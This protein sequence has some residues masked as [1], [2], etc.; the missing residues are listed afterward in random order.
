[1]IA[2]VHLAD[3]GFAAAV[4]LRRPRADGLIN[5]DVAL[6]LPLSSSPVRV[7]GGRAGLIA[8]WESEDALDRFLGSHPLAAKFAGGWHARLEPLRRWGSW[9]GLPKTVPMDR[10][11]DYD[12]PAV[13]LTLGRLR[14]S[15]TIRFLRASRRAE[16]QAVGSHGLAWATALAR[17]PFVATCSIW[18]SSRSIADYAFGALGNGHP[19]AMAAHDAKPFHKESAFVRFRPYAVQGELSGRNPLAGRVLSG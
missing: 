10:D 11:V 16:Q 7:L 9:P 8:F 13:V 6:A 19:D 14:L 15:Q 2:S 5:S 17:P 18:D 1:M 4:T 12:G 3:L